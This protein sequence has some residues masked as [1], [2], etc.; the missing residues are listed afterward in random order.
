MDKLNNRA[1]CARASNARSLLLL[2]YDA[3]GSLFTGRLDIHETTLVVT[4][5]LIRPSVRPRSPITSN[6]DARRRLCPHN[7]LYVSLLV[8]VEL[9]SQA[10]E[11][12]RATVAAATA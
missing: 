3:I 10:D 7:A 4:T 2:L 6:Q 8:P 9:V 5:A 11:T 12:S 1:L